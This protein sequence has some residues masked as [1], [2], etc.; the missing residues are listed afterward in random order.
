MTRRYHFAHCYIRWHQEKTEDWW[1]SIRDGA[2]CPTAEQEAFLQC[3]VGRCAQEQKELQ[4]LQA[5]K[6]KKL[7]QQSRQR[8]QKGKA[9]KS[10]KTDLTEPER[11]CLFGIPGSGKSTCIKHL[12]SFFTEALGWTEGTDFQLLAS[13]NIMAALIGG[14]T[15]HSWGGILVNRTK[16]LEKT[17]T[18][19]SE[20]DVNALF[21]KILSCR[22][23]I[24]DETSTASLSLLGMLDS[25][26]RRAAQGQSPYARI[27]G[28]PM[29]F[30]GL[31]IIFAGDL[32]RLP[33]VKGKAIFSDP[34]HGGLLAEEQTIAKMFWMTVDPIRHFFELTA[35]QR[36]KEEWLQAV[37]E[38]DRY[39]TES[40]EMYCFIH[41]LPTRNPG[42]WLPSSNAPACGVHDCQQLAQVWQNNRDN[43]VLLP[44]STRQAQK[45][46]FCQAE[47]KRRHWIILGND[48]SKA[49]MYRKELFADAP[50]VHP[51]RAPSYHAQH[52]RSLNFAHAH[53]RQLIWVV[54][55]DRLQTKEK[56]R[57]VEQEQARKDRWLEYH[58]RFTNGIPGILPLVLGLPIRFTSTPVP[59][60]RE[61]GIFKN[62]RGVVRGWKLDPAE[63]ARLIE[64]GLQP[65][66][67]LKTR[68]LDICIE[69]PTS[70]LLLQH[71]KRMYA[72]KMTVRNW[73]LDRDNQV[74]VKRHGFP[75]VP[76]FGGT[77][78]A[79]CGDTLKACLGDLM[80]WNYLPTLDNAL[81]AYIIKSRI[82]E[83]DKLLLAQPYSPMLFRQGVQPGPHILRQ[84]LRQ[85]ITPKEAK[86]KW[87]DVQKK[88]SATAH[89]GTNMEGQASI[90][91]SSLHGSERW[92]RRY[93]KHPRLHRLV[94]P[95]A[96]HHLAGHHPERGCRFVL[97]AM[98][99]QNEKGT[100]G[101]RA[102]TGQTSAA[103][104]FM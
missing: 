26:L 96:R 57:S 87:K 98:S 41:G 8:K 89:P 47:R 93:E 72:L 35:N 102:S 49:A 81:R 33:P 76:D 51:F 61:I 53:N 7:Q 10:Q 22:W 55:D 13:Q 100:C 83:G 17:H 69:V 9:P 75:I 91:M 101:Q 40:W 43:G 5:K 2:E 16:A 30:G 65:E 80:K 31:N 27:R 45:C 95:G 94:A 44:W 90:T 78:H 88:R 28:R 63:E 66:V 4:A 14:E 20:G 6:H 48:E 67:V 59:G 77:A 32:W 11:I 82:R 70:K 21:E 36:T 52:L 97:L 38:A 84:V 12:R 74:Q 92:A 29:P 62:Q 37:L 85:D 15:I 104:T 79:Y 23:I 73:S 58:D 60:D 1:T 50:F 18:K 54:A 71:G 46:V 68:P 99:A 25:Y 64:Q 86:A 34:F 39:G 19:A 24:I 103:R 42:S 56:D 3:V